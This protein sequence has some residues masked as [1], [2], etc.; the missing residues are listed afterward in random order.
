MHRDAANYR[1]ISSPAAIIIH[2]GAR[3]GIAKNS[4]LM[5]FPGAM[6]KKAQLLVRAGFLNVLLFT[7]TVVGAYFTW[8]G[9]F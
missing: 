4:A 6:A 9:Y 7:C 3:G 1:D 8:V 2:I 5:L